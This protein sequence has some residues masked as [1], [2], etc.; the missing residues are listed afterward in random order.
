MTAPMAIGIGLSSHDL[1]SGHRRRGEIAAAVPKVSLEGE[2]APNALDSLLF[3][4]RDDMRPFCPGSLPRSTCRS[5]RRLDHAA[6][7]TQRD[8]AGYGSAVG[9]HKPP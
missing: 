1:C 9:V 2:F 7:V 5:S 6:P 4:H 3:R 8:M